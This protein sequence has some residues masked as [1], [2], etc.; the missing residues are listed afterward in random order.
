MGAREVLTSIHNWMGG[1]RR[2]VMMNRLA[3]GALLS[4][5]GLILI[6][7]AVLLL[8]TFGHFSGSVRAVL[9]GVWGVSALLAL[10][11]GIVWPLLRYTV[12][13]PTDKKLA[14][15]YAEAIPN[16]KDRVLNALQLLDRVENA[17]KEGYSTD[18]M[19][20]AGRGVAEDLVPINPKTLPDKKTVKSGLRYAMV[21]GVAA[22]LVLAIAGRPILSAAERVMKPGEE[23][24]KPSPFT[25]SITPGDVE[26]V[27]GDSLV[28][29]IHAE[30]ETP[31]QVTLT[32][33]EIGKTAGEPI[34]LNGDNGEFKYTYKGITSSFNY[35]AYSG[36]VTTEQHKVSVRELP[37]VRFLSVRLSPPAYTG[38]EEKVLEENVGD[39]SAVV[40]T[41]AKLSIASTK[42]LQAATIEFLK[43]GTEK[44]EI[45]STLDLRRKGHAAREYLKFPR[46]VTTASA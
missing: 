1:L 43:A 34:T 45:L 6:S 31:K 20:E 9:L 28:V 38:L 8:E 2:A 39:I 46:T 41:S 25:L 5:A 30:G 22:I 36:R 21:M 7:L 37:A 17:N 35:W 12:F 32:R 16:V 13:A 3:S 42:P 15:D 10:G 11:L 19:L 44:E 14:G 33:M 26:L 4:L 23:F 27:R 24:A 29:S 18:L 40:G